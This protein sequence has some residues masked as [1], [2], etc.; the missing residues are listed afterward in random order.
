MA[1]GQM[2]TIYNAQRSSWKLHIP[3]VSGAALCC[4][5][6]RY[7]QVKYQSLLEPEEIISISRERTNEHK[8]LLDF[9][10][11]SFP[12][13]QHQPD[14]KFLEDLQHALARSP[15]LLLPKRS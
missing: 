7:Y 10:S 4:C 9:F 8:V 5:F 12:Q 15:Y 11:P 6:W 2:W 13:V 1:Q 3:N 14:Q